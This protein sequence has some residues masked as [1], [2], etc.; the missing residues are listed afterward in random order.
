MTRLQEFMEMITGK[1]DNKEQYEQMKAQGAEFPYARHINTAC[2][3]RILHLPEDFK[4]IFMVEE[5]YYTTGDK[6]HGSPHLFLFTEE[7]E[8]ILLTS[9]DLP[10]GADKQSFTY[11]T[12]GEVEY[13]ELKASEKF[14]PALYKE[15]AGVWEGGSVS[16][17]TPVL[18]FVL[19]EKFS[20][21][22][23]EVS[24]SMEMNGR[25]TFG[26]DEPII[27]RRV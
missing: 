14:T 2:N 12:M 11:E 3:N 25:R 15:K 18:K 20:H 7:E 8:G 1:F 21:K 19:H 22:Q 17:F 24:E 4:G 27:Y 6:T 23:L 10:E 16:M 26:Y 5:S 13:G 9:Y